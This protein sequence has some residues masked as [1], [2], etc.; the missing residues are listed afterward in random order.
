VRILL[1]HDEIGLARA[2]KIRKDPV[3]RLGY[4]EVFVVLLKSHMERIRIKI[5]TRRKMSKRRIADSTAA[6]FDS[7]GHVYEDFLALDGYQAVASSSYETDD[8]HYIEARLVQH[9]EELSPPRWRTG[10]WMVWSPS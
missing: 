4:P 1:L 3:F 5:V 10:P 7:K 8:I 6:N 9:R 2:S